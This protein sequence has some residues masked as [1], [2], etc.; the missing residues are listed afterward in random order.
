MEMAQWSLDRLRMLLRPPPHTDQSLTRAR[1][2]LA[3]SLRLGVGRDGARQTKMEGS[4][5]RNATNPIIFVGYV[6]TKPHADQYRW[7]LGYTGAAG[8]SE[9]DT[10]IRDI[11]PTDLDRWCEYIV[12][13]AC[14]AVAWVG[15]GRRC[16]AR[17]CCFSPYVDVLHTLSL[18]VCMWGCRPVCTPLTGCAVVVAETGRA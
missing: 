11:D 3:L 6:V 17:D 12:Y 9:A 5:L 13:K 8:A 14:V 1:V 16:C 4:L 7:L 10:G 18:S 15:L 2:C